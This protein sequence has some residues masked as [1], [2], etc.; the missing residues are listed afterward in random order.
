MIVGD[1]QELELHRGRGRSARL[2]IGGVPHAYHWRCQF[3]CR[4]WDGLAEIAD[5]PGSRVRATVIGRRLIGLDVGGR[6]LLSPGPERRRWIL[7]DVVLTGIGGFL[8]LG[9]IAGAAG[10]ARDLRDAW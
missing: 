4:P 3:D 10:K 7:R 6:R 9:F 8:A 2:W 5:A 1:V